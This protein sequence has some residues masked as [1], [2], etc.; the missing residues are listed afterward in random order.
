MLSAS[1]LRIVH[2]LVGPD[3]TSRECRVRSSTDKMSS[4]TR[5]RPRERAWPE[6]WIRGLKEASGTAEPG[7]QVLCGRRQFVDMVVTGNREAVPDVSDSTDEF[8][9]GV[10]GKAS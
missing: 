4:A 5:A 8:G 9:L 3:A 7:C 2:R 1:L 6:P 10:L